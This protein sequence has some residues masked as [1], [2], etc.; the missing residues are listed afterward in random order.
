VE[1]LGFADAEDDLGLP[2][3]LLPDGGVVPDGVEPGVTNPKFAF[4]EVVVGK[5]GCGAANTVTGV[6]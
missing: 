5:V 3:G 1:I 4:E 2:V 6:T